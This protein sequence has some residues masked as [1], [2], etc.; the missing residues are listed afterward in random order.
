MEL[1]RAG[2]IQAHLQAMSR[3]P[4]DAAYFLA[5]QIY[6]R[7]VSDKSAIVR[8]YPA[9]S[10]YVYGELL[11][12]F[13]AYVSLILHGRCRCLH[14]IPLSDICRATNLSS[15]QLFVDLGSGVSNAV[16]MSSMLTGCESRESPVEGIQSPYK[17]HLSLHDNRWFR[18]AQGN[19]SNWSC[20]H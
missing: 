4:T 11:P 8:N 7:Q 16:V 1:K 18:G 5:E 17:I 9:F 6:Q 20:S 2:R 19:P 10:D 12:V 14:P 3:L 15:S 13:I